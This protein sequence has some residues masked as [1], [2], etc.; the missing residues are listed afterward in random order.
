MTNLIG[1]TEA[2]ETATGKIKARVKK[3]QDDRLA[4][5]DINPPEGMSFCKLAL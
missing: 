3:R 5:L 1:K 4:A 2:K